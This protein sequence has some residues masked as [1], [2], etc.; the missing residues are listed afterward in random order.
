M[1]YRSNLLA[2]RLAWAC[3]AILLMAAVTWGAGQVVQRARKSYIAYA[4][5]QSPP[6]Q[7]RTPEGETRFVGSYSVTVASDD[8]NFNEA[9]ARRQFELISRAQATGKAA[10]VKSRETD[11]GTVVTYQ[12]KLD[13]G[14]VVTWNGSPEDVMT[15]EQRAERQKQMAEL[16]AARRFQF[17]R[18]FTTPDGVTMYNYRVRLPDG[19]NVP[20][21]SLLPDHDPE[22]AKQLRQEIDRA[23]DQHQGTLAGVIEPLKGVAVPRGMEPPGSTKLY[24]Y[25]VKLSN[26]DTSMYS[27]PDPPAKE[28]A[29]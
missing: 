15:P 12:V 1:G 9:D 14:R 25:K 8:A 24:T 21:N 17:V 29:K 13:D 18:K 27:T 28:D 19:T 11:F 3:A 4:G 20:Y 10:V 22:R 16:L 26:G 2:V 23:K 7:V 5:P 6:I